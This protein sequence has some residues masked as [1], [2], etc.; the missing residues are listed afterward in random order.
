TASAPGRIEWKAAVT[1]AAEPTTTQLEVPALEASPDPPASPLDERATVA[2]PIYDVDTSAQHHRRILALEVGAPGV[3]AL[4][5]GLGL[6]ARGVYTDAH[7][8]SAPRG[9][10]SNVCTPDGVA[11]LD[12]AR[13]W[14]LAS[15][16]GVGVGVAAIAAGAVL[17]ATAP[18]PVRKERRLVRVVP[19]G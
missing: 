7:G 16:I 12:R 14:A 15:D 19:T 6:H 1:I 8:G 18:G 3:V 17:W 5:V 2:P 4:A 13:T 11:M 9:D 10:A